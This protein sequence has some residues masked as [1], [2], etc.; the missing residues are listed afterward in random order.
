MKKTQKIERR[1]AVRRHVERVSREAAQ[2]GRLVP[3]DEDRAFAASV[4]GQPLTGVLAAELF[5]HN[6]ARLRRFSA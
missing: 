6:V 4:E 5:V 3:S 2:N 1:E